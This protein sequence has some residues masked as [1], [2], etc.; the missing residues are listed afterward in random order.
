MVVI[1]EVLSFNHYGS[2]NYKYK[3]E[4]KVVDD[5]LIDK[6]LHL[7]YHGTKCRF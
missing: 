1:K 5:F 3:E 2:G 4:K 7:V 6:T